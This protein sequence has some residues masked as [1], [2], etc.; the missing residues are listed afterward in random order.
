MNLYTVIVTMLIAITYLFVFKVTAQS[1]QQ[2]LSLLE[3]LYAKMSGACE[4]TTLS[5]TFMAKN[6]VSF[7]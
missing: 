1:D 2:N 7:I 6:F 5:L 3:N 4:C